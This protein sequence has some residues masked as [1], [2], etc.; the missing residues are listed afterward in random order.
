MVAVDSTKV[1]GCLNGIGERDG[2]GTET[3]EAVL[4]GNSV[5]DLK[6]ELGTGGG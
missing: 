4:G 2:G 6:G 3:E 5:G 1:D